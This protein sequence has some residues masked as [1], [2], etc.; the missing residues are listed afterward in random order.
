MCTIVTRAG[1]QVGG[2][3]RQN[4]VH[5]PCINI[6]VTKFMRFTANETAEVTD[7]ST[8]QAV[9]TLLTQAAQVRISS[10]ST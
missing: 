4:V 2:E 10:R 1:V 3:V 8:L 7:F 6:Y 5:I 9:K